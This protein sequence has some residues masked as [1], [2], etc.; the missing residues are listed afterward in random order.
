MWPV[1]KLTL[2]RHET[3][4]AGYIQE[5]TC[6][7]HILIIVVNTQAKIGS[8]IPFLTTTTYATWSLIHLRASLWSPPI[9]KLTC[10]MH[11]L[12]Y[13]LL[14]DAHI[15]FIRASCVPPLSLIT[16]RSSAPIKRAFSI[17]RNP[18]RPQSTLYLKI[19]A[20]QI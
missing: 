13:L 1:P 14:L 7:L 20:P 3:P 4:G 2:V 9:L 18:L 8:I 5:Q 6:N 10:S 15:L 12:K 16:L 17:Q 11:V 19:Y